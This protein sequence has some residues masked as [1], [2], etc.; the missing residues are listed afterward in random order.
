[1]AFYIYTS[2]TRDCVLFL[3][4]R[5][6]AA[7]GVYRTALFKSMP[8]EEWLRDYADFAD[9]VQNGVR[10]ARAL[11][12]KQHR[13]CP[14]YTYSPPGSM[15]GPLLGQSIQTRR[16]AKRLLRK[17]GAWKSPLPTHSPGAPARPRRTL[18]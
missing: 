7:L 14:E 15:R 11:L 6:D 12:L 16:A 13:G 5:V 4:D 2:Q 9:A 1:M 10:D 8:E 3:L 17:L 18:H